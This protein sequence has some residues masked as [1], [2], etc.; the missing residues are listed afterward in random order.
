[1]SN[2]FNQE[3]KKI[4][5]D[6][7][8]TMVEKKMFFKDS[9]NY[10]LLSYISPKCHRTF[11]IIILLFTS[12]ILYILSEE[13]IKLLPIKQPLPIMVNAKDS[14]IYYPAIKSLRKPY[15]TDVISINEMVAR[16]LI[17]NYITQRESYDF[18][19]ANI[20]DIN[21]KLEFIRN[22]SS[23]KEYRNFKKY[24][25]RTNPLSPVRFF[26]KDSYNK[27]DII[28]VAFEKEENKNLL[29]IAQ[30][31]LYISLAKEAVVNYKIT[32][33]IGNKTSVTKKKARIFFSFSGINKKSGT[34]K[35]ELD[36][37]VNNF[38]NLKVK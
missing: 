11:L 16:Y 12:S 28:S 36:F 35:K 30:D 19:T 25:D 10:Y 4:Y 23:S 7:V 14:S 17:E 31:F 32:R 29:K 2:K 38:I 5:N 13:I 9:V 33:Y 22:N 37:T 1:M 26:G 8:T 34:L 18:R 20:N 24:F 27:V 21:N 3:Q 6:Y 15:D